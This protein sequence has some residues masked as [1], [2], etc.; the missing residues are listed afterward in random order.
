MR[1]NHP[2]PRLGFKQTAPIQTNKFWGNLALATRKQGVWTHPYLVGFSNGDGNAGGRGL[3][4][5]HVSRSQTVLGPGNPAS[6]Y[7]NPIGIHSI[8]LSAKELGNGASMTLDSLRGFSVNMNM[9]P[10]PNAA[11]IITFPLLQGMAFV[12][13]VYSNAAPLIQS[14]VFFK[15]M[16]Y[17]GKLAGREIQWYSV[18]LADDT[19]WLIYISPS[20]HSPVVP[21]LTFAS[22]EKLVGSVPFSGS[23]QIAKNPN[24]STSKV[25]YDRHAGV[26][27]LRGAV[28]ASVNQTLGKYQ[29]YWTKGGDIATPLLMFALDHHLQA[30]PPGFSSQSRS[31]LRLETTTKGMA[32]A[33]V[34]DTWLME[35]KNLPVDMDFAPWTPKLRSSTNFSPLAKTWI[36]KAAAAELNQ[37]FAAQSNLDSMYFSGKV[38]A[39]L[40]PALQRQLLTT[41]KRL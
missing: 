2:V 31:A 23:I 18:I 17:G 19:E 12:T 27:P 30:L 39:F 3:Y 33:V 13:G 22:K 5:S 4:V 11:P 37:D 41:H 32:A 24:G 36:R 16:T 34:G 15:T 29:L 20:G 40:A 6:Y 7:V 28:Q 10:Q 1:S 9:A 8:I 14:D 21:T 38:M 26:Y 25:F 35:E